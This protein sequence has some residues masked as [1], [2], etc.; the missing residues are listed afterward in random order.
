MAI[1]INTFYG[2]ETK[3]RLAKKAGGGR[4]DDRLFVFSSGLTEKTK[5]LKLVISWGKTGF[6]QNQHATAIT[7]MFKNFV[8]FWFNI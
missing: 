6:S 5:P 1:S 3:Q 8:S 2:P 7:L 4:N